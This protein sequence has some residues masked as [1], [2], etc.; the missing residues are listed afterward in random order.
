MTPAARVRA[1]RRWAG[2]VALAILCIT[3]IEVLALWNDINGKAL[4]TSLA[5]IGG[6]AG[7]ALG[8]V[9]K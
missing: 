8:R 1:K 3:I 2:V 5:G 6:L 7:A 4:A 9:M